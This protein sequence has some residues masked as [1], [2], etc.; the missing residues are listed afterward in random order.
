[1]KLFPLNLKTCEIQIIVFRGRYAHGQRLEKSQEMM[2]VQGQARQGRGKG[3]D[4]H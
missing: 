2:S 1:M 3:A 4:M